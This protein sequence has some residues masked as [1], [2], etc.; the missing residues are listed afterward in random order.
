MRHP[1]NPPIIPPL[2]HDIP[3]VDGIT[4]ELPGFTK[5]IRRDTGHGQRPLFMVQIKQFLMNPYIGTVING[6]ERHIPYDP[7]AFTVAI[8][9]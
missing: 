4:P 3:S 5:I 2:F 1:L 9:L 8:V 6:I 7:H